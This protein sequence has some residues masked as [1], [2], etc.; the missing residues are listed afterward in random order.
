MV[1]VMKKVNII[2]LAIVLVGLSGCELLKKEEKVLYCSMPDDSIER[3]VN[4]NEFSSFEG[5]ISVDDVIPFFL[6]NQNEFSFYLNEPSFIEENFMEN[7]YS[8]DVYKYSITEN[9]LY[10]LGKNRLAPSY[11]FEVND[12]DIRTSYITEIDGEK[13]MIEYVHTP[14]YE[15]Q[16]Y[17]LYLGERKLLEKKA[18]PLH[19]PSF[20]VN[21]DEVYMWHHGVSYVTLYKIVDGNLEEVINKENM[22]GKRASSNFKV[23]AIV[24]GNASA[25]TFSDSNQTISVQ[26]YNKNERLYEID[27]PYA[28]DEKMKHFIQNYTVIDD[29]RL[30]TLEFVFEGNEAFGDNEK[31][32]AVIRSSNNEIIGSTEYSGDLSFFHLTKLDS[33]IFFAVDNG[34]NPYVITTFDN[35][36]EINKISIE[37]TDEN[38]IL[39]TLVNDDLFILMGKNGTIHLY[40]KKTFINKYKLNGC[41]DKE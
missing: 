4:F 34:W 6:N 38:T 27:Y 41:I 12:Y 25:F 11:K 31:N 18:T 20:Q 22:D 2:L 23:A 35:E 10:N 17:N 14:R 36:V 5:D 33:D 30:L 29:E 1:F 19:F 16:Y 40:D 24:D 7:G 26:F 21:N 3:V 37:W 28:G 13:L 32:L 15:D 9:K 39:R 8:K